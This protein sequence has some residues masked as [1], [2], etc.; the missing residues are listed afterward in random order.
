MISFIYFS[1]I[2]LV[3]FHSSSIPSL[4]DS[5]TIWVVFFRCCECWFLCIVM[6]RCYYWLCMLSLNMPLYST[7][8]FPPLAILSFLVRYNHHYSVYTLV[9]E[10]TK[11]FW[12][13]NESTKYPYFNEY[14]LSFIFYSVIFN[15]Y[16]DIMILH[17]A[18]NVHIRI[19]STDLVE[20]METNT[21]EEKNMYKVEQQQNKGFVS[22]F[23]RS[24]TFFLFLDDKTFFFRHLKHNRSYIPI[25]IIK[26]MHYI[27]YGATNNTLYDVS[28]TFLHLILCINKKISKC[29][30]H[31]II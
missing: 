31:H 20:S 11:S 17:I 18:F 10:C 28:C 19:E 21:I 5:L 25:K 2:L 6:Y 13:M 30:R 15:F 14:A 23:T 29:C 27:K 26:R 4:L 8:A 12:P 22:R 7:L 1:Y 24:K 16:Y 9:R 3:C